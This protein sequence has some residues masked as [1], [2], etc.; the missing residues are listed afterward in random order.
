VLA[1]GG[2]ARDVGACPIYRRGALGLG[3]H[4]KN[5]GGGALAAGLAW[6]ARGYCWA[7]EGKMG[8]GGREERERRERAAEGEEAQGR[9]SLFFSFFFSISF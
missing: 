7:A 9:F 1:T 5:G 8:R 2:R 6:A 3:T 4:A